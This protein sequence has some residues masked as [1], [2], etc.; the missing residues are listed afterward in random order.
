MHPRQHECA[1]NRQAKS[2]VNCR[3][4]AITIQS[5]HGAPWLSS[6]YL[7]LQYTGGGEV[8]GKKPIRQLKDSSNVI[9]ETFEYIEY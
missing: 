2:G 8:H 4:E 1:N 3:G 6:E 5:A 9:V 7:E